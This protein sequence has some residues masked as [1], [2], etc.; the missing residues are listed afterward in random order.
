MPVNTAVESRPRKRAARVSRP[1]LSPAQK[2]L[3][4]QIASYAAVPNPESLL[5]ECVEG[6]VSHEHA[7]W[8][9]DREEGSGRIRGRG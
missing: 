2:R 1:A 8:A 5:G 3:E 4:D 7:V 6:L 9:S